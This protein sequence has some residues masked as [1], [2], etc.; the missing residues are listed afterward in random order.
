M[1][2]VI[3]KFY[4]HKEGLARVIFGCQMFEWDKTQGVWRKCRNEDQVLYEGIKISQKEAES[5]IYRSWFDLTGRYLPE[6]KV[7]TK[8][9]ELAVV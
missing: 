6:E 9:F 3:T 4:S 7:V 2:E 8:L 5:F 1:Q